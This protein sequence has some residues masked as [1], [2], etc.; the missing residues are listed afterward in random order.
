MAV[1]RPNHYYGIKDKI[2]ETERFPSPEAAISIAVVDEPEA[3]RLKV[4]TGEQQKLLEAG[5]AVRFIKFTD[6][7]D[8]LFCTF[9]I[10]L[11]KNIRKEYAKLTMLIRQKLLV[12]V[13]QNEAAAVLLS[14]F[15][16]RYG[17]RPLTLER[18]LAELLESF[19]QND[20]EYLGELE[21]RITE[22]EERAMDGEVADFNHQMVHIRKEL[23]YLHNYYAQFQDL[24]DCFQDSENDFFAENRYFRYLSDKMSRLYGECQ[25]LREYS[26]QVREFY[27]AQVDVKQ[28]TIMKFLT[29]VTTIF[30][31]LTLITGWYGMNFAGM[32]ELSWRFGY[33]LVIFVSALIL[34]IC[35]WIFKKKKFF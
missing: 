34:L 35:I 18:L 23:L 32:P 31:P 2:Y 28:N 14:S 1:F 26:M 10:P 8:Y 6:Y 30:L 13:V 5:N 11:Q 16:P 12:I 25:M 19:V 20:L 7:E 24:A 33:P 4:M 3:E 27:Q 29:G 22:L 17:G 9:H 21:D 15:T